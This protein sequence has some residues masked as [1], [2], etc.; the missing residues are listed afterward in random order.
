MTCIQQD[1]QLRIGR[2]ALL[3]D[4]RQ[5]VEAVGGTFFDVDMIRNSERDA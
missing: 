5:A 2:V 3:D 1:L 4:G